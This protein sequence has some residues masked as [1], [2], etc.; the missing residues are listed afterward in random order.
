MRGFEAL[1]AFLLIA[2]LASSV[3]A[4]YWFQSGA[5]AGSN[6]AQNNGASVQIETVAPQTLKNGSL[7]FWV[8]ES[9]PNGGFVQV[10]YLIE[11]ETGNY[12][13]NC[14][15]F[16]CS[17]SENLKAGD[18]EWFYEYFLPGNNSTFFGSTGPDGS[19]GNNTQFNTYGFYSLGDNWYFLFN[20]KTIGSADLGTSSSGPY[21]P[22]AFAEIANTSDANTYMKSVIFAN[23]SAYKY[24][25]FLPVQ[26]ATGAI[27]YGIGSKTN[28]AN[29][30]GVQEIGNRINYFEVGSGLPTS[31]NNSRLWSLGFRLTV[32]SKYGGVS[33]RNSYTAY[34]TVNLSAPELVSLGNMTRSVFSGWSGKGLGSYTG[35]MNN[36]SMTL[37]DNVT[38]TANWQVQYFINVSSTYSSATGSG[39]Y[40][41]STYARYSIGNTTIYQNGTPRYRFTGW[42]DGNRNASTSVFVQGPENISAIWQYKEVLV[43][44]NANG[45]ALS[46]VGPF[47][48]SGQLTNSTPFLDANGSQRV[49]GAYYKGVLLLSNYVLSPNSPM[50]AYIKLP[51]YNVT[52]SSKGFFGFPVAASGTVRFENGT[53]RNLTLGYNGTVS[54]PNVPDGYA[55]LSLSYL[56]LKQNLIASGGNTATAYFISIYAIVA[57]IALLLLAALA[58]RFANRRQQNKDKL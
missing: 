57:I 42:N 2:F 40:G 49:Q 17:S 13:I 56:D 33:S 20:N 50:L 29:P 12:P 27:N 6:A 21:I 22:L 26:T 39:W 7:A 38:E 19:A 15:A 54:I 16:G 48:I 45:E 37:E 51:V 55:N 46:G 8:G 41:N 52:V 34:S 30:Y 47:R 10:G 53:E 23:L 44:E 25:A 35:T 32:N 1:L 31:T 3:H 43:G 24:R 9:L 14:T 18:A 11:N 36:V 58:Y 5:R 4:E 28:I